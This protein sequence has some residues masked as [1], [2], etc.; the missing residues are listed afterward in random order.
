MHDKISSVG[1]IDKFPISKKVIHAAR[2][3]HGVYVESLKNKEEEENKQK[4]RNAIKDKVIELE[5]KKIKLL[6]DVKE[7]LS[8]ID[9][10]IIDLRA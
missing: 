1:D 9:D 7:K 8:A 2:N 10:E 6:N 3:A 5:A 4:K